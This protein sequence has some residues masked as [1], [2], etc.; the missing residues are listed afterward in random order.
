MAGLLVLAHENICQISSRGRVSTSGEKV[1]MSVYFFLL[2]PP[3]LPSFSPVLRLIIRLYIQ[4]YCKKKCS[5]LRIMKRFYC[6]TAFTATLHS[7]IC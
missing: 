7:T 3:A 5:N 1:F 4:I 6:I 2:F